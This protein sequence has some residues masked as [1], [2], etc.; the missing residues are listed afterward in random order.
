MQ[1]G[2]HQDTQ[3]KKWTKELKG[4]KIL[5]D[6]KNPLRNYIEK[7]LPTMDL[8]CFPNR[9]KNKVDLSIGDPTISLEFR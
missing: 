3:R 1:A 8:S 6:V 2:C 4:N 5:A 9:P 7:E